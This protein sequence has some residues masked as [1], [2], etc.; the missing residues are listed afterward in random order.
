MPLGQRKLLNK[1]TSNTVD[2]NFVRGP[3][4][5]Y[6]PNADA[7]SHTAYPNYDPKRYLY[8]KQIERHNNQWL[9]DYSLHLRCPTHVC[10]SSI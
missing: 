1:S 6:I 2:T 3:Q 10:V 4:L 7:S 8:G 9:N 5:P